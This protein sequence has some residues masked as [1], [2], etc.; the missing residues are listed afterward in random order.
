MLLQQLLA[1]SL[2]L[3]ELGLQVLVRVKV[4][5]A[6]TIQRSL[7]FLNFL[8]GPVQFGDIAAH[9]SRH[10]AKVFA[11]SNEQRPTLGSSC[12]KL[13]QRARERGQVLLNGGILQGR[14]KIFQC[15]DQ[16]ARISLAEPALQRIF[17]GSPFLA[18]GIAEHKKL[19]LQFRQL[20]HQSISNHRRSELAL[21]RQFLQRADR[22]ADTV[23]QGLH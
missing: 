2:E 8:I 13:H 12:S 16:R 17:D 23:G 7:E 19:L 1:V 15:L 20:P 6:E 11:E 21:R 14:P 4:I 22:H 5:H 9:S 3:I 10:V 18:H